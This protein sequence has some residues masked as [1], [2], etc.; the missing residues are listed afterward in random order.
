M[1]SSTEGRKGQLLTVQDDL[2][3]SVELQPLQQVQELLHC[4]QPHS[5]PPHELPRDADPC[6]LHALDFP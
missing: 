4:R 3:C 1:R 2:S 5:P 6:L